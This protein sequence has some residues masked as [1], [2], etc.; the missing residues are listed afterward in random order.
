MHEGSVMIEWGCQHFGVGDKHFCLCYLVQSWTQTNHSNL[1]Q[2]LLYQ[3]LI[4]T[5]TYVLIYVS[6]MFWEPRILT[7]VPS[8]S[9]SND[10]SD[11][12][13]SDLSRV[14]WEV[15]ES[16]EMAGLL[17][18]DMLVMGWCKHEGWTAALHQR[19]DVQSSVTWT[20][21]IR[22]YSTWRTFVSGTYVECR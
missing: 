14:T 8:G 7:N 17:V 16:S 9:C 1:W 15:E 22:S 2:C 12:L 5:C 21:Y 4:F 10:E 6:S 19:S 11:M 3:D 13:S 18:C 20:I